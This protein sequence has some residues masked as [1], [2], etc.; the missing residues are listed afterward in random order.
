LR[1][2]GEHLNNIRGIAL[3]MVLWVLVLLMVMVMSFTYM[4]RI[5]TDSEVFFADKIKNDFILEGAIHRAILEIQYAKLHPDEE[6]IWNLRGLLNRGTIDGEEYWVRIY[7]ESTRL[8][9]NHTADVILKGLLRHLGVEK[10]R[11]EVIVD[12]LLDWR[13]KDNLHR[14]NGA[15]DEYYSSLP[16]PY[17]CKNSN[18]EAVEELLLIKGMD[19]DI[20]Y[21]NENKKGLRDYV[22]V[23][24]LSGMLNIN[25]APRELLL[26]IPGFSEELV[27]TVIQYRKEQ[28]IR[29]PAELQ[30]LIGGAYA[31]VGRFLTVG[32]EGTFRIE[33]FSGRGTSSLEAVVRLDSAGFKILYWKRG[34]KTKEINNERTSEQG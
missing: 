30:S 13:D 17:R 11:I 1:C 14:L 26:S 29:N 6:D 8:D 33:A 3:L 20:F 5:E 21:G 7:P 12:S 27:E 23:Y 32:D 10:E 16:R 25:T 18:L 28:P 15:E 19:E 4:T 24:S 22:T 9:L 31:S 2:L 34:I